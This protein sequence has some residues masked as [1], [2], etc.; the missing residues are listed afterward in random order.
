MK[1]VSFVISSVILGI[2]VANFVVS[3]LSLLKR[4]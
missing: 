3:L 1:K 4:D 2:S